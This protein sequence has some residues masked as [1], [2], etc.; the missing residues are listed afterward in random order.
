ME[1]QELGAI[2]QTTTAAQ[3]TASGAD[4][5]SG[6]NGAAAKAPL[7]SFSELARAAS[8]AVIA[9]IAVALIMRRL[10]IAVSLAA[11]LVI[12]LGMYAGIYSFV[13]G[14]TKVISAIV[15]G[16]GGVSAGQY[17]PQFILATL[18]KFIGIGVVLYSIFRFLHIN[19]LMMLAGFLIGQVA[20]TVTCLRSLIATPLLG[21]KSASRS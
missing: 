11:G 10:G 19:L 21:G 17:M 4:T 8:M 2:E 1:K 15:G 16:K 6:A 3:A 12:C 7:P 18:G 13:N 9:A 5:V 20:I 14:A